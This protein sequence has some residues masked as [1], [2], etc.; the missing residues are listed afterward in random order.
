MNLER[1]RY[2]VAVS[3]LLYAPPALLIWILIHMFIHFWRR[4]GIV[5]SYLCFSVIM[6]LLGWGMWLAKDLVLGA[7]YGTQP[8]LIAL[9][10]VCVSVSVWI[11]SRRRR[12]LDFRTMIGLPE[13]M[14][15]GRQRVL[16]TSRAYGWVR[17]PR[18]LETTLFVLAGAL[19]ANYLVLYI[20]WLASLPL[21]HMIV[22]LEERELYEAFGREYLDYCAHVPR[23]IPKRLW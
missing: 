6:L 5:W 21:L 8:L 19:F 15:E 13:L 9:S 18:Y 20:A 7:E 16:L 23:Y 10:L 14:K 22:L 4:I 1:L 2:I 3:V 12:H 11:A 17:N